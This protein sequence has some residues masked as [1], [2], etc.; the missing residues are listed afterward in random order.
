[1]ERKTEVLY[2]AIDAVGRGVQF[3]KNVIGKM[4]LCY[5]Y[6]G[7]SVVIEI[8]EYRNGYS[9]IYKYRKNMVF[10]T[11]GTTSISPTILGCNLQK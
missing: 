3:M 2:G 5:D 4:D 7:Q 9:N 8:P 10:R 11:Y 1:M 6:K